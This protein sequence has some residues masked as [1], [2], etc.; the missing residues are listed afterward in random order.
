MIHFQHIEYLLAL[1]ALPFIIW[2]F[3]HV[4]KWK[5]KTAKKIGDPALV[6]L[7][8]S[9]F[10]F[11]KFR[12]KFYLM[13]AA[14]VLCAFAVAGLAEPDQT[15]KV[16][17][18]G[19]DIVIALDV[20]RSMLATDIKPSRLERAKQLI[21]MIIDQSPE[22][23]IGLVIF[24]GRAYLQMPLT[25]DHEAAKMYVNT[26]HPND[27]P[28]QG[29]VISDALRMSEA[30]FNPNDKSY[31]SILLIS[32]GE[33]H[34]DEAITVAKELGKNGI[35]I[36]TIGIGSPSGSP[37]T[38]SSTGEYI[39]DEKG[40]TVISKLNEDELQ[41]IAN[42]AHGIYQLY[43]D[44][45]VIAQNIKNQLAN[46]EKETVLS[47]S[48][49]TSFK[50]YYYYFLIVA[51][52]LLIIESVM[53]EKRKS[54][55][56]MASLPIIFLFLI[57]ALPAHSQNRIIYK[58]NKAFD[59]K[60]YDEAEKE[61]RSVPEN[62]DKNPTAMF[63]LG[64]TL[65]RKEKNDEAVKAFDEVI[66]N[67]NDNTLKQKA[68]Y[69]KGVAY[70]KADKLPECITAYKNALLLDPHDEDARQN[71]Q[72]ALKMQQEQQKQHQKDQDKKQDKKDQKKN[73][74]SKN[75]QQQQQ[76]NQPQP[77]P[78]KLSKKDAE[79]KLKSLEQNEKELHNR[80]KSPGRS[81]DQPIK[82]W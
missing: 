9:E 11:R 35:M 46:I 7:L 33:D 6:K 39:T 62:S 50:Q 55:P 68:F 38:D 51:F 82:D 31:K 15:H 81:N 60:K 8:I 43:T 32:D 52:I 78:S 30:S 77:Q 75:D 70:Q 57:F 40:Q 76:N 58:G 16:S 18:T 42:S 5:K 64:N 56:K 3:I 48:S 65:Y 61:Y 17:R 74:S 44:P 29:T 49:Y 73:Q 79:E 67:T 2:S 66:R 24:A 69:N 41:K 13:A 45:E 54:I 53:G 1:A 36:N 14:F 71:L 37:I 34:D 21:S 63:N 80:Q 59:E 25:I 20:S 22:D 26:S 47:D 27:V 10:S 12:I 72:R 23:K 4:I 28:T 19:T